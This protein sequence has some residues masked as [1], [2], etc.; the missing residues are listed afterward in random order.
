MFISANES[1]L[2]VRIKKNGMQIPIPY[3]Q[4]VE[5]LFKKLPTPQDML[6]HSALGI[7]GEAGELVDCIK[8][9]TIY[10][11]ELD[12]SNLIEE[13]GDLMFYI[14]T[15]M[16]AHNISLREI[17]QTNADKLSVRYKGMVYT[18]KAAQDREDKK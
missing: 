12:I 6:N 1:L 4:F 9:H 14:Q 16:L 17:L 2:H 10:G 3:E 7:A 11:K 15:L 5:T 8:K 13:L 18:D